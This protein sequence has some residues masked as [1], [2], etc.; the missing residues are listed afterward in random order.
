MLCSRR[1]PLHAAQQFYM[2]WFLALTVVCVGQPEALEVYYSVMGTPGVFG[3]KVEIDAMS[4][5]LGR[6]IHMYYFHGERQDSK[7]VHQPA[8]I[9]D[10]GYK[11]RREINLLHSVSGRHFSPMIKNDLLKVLKK[12]KES[13]K[14]ALQDPGAVGLSAGKAGVGIVLKVRCTACPDVL[15]G[16]V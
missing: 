7:G 2:F 15:G 4:M 9:F 16:R 3:E 8:E 1:R 5:V 13:A 10:Q 12:E 14:F 11:G 6:K